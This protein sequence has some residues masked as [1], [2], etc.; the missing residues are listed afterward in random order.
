MIRRLEA[1]RVSCVKRAVGVRHS[2]TNPSLLLTHRYWGYVAECI[3]QSSALVGVV[4][5]I[6]ANKTFV[7]KGRALIRCSLSTKTLAEHVQVWWSHFLPLLANGQ[8]TLQENGGS[9]LSDMKLNPTALLLDR[10]HAGTPK[11]PHSTTIAMPSCATHSS[12]P[13]LWTFSTI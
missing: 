5:S 7:G 8:L 6:A 3:D 4:N 11:L 1:L 12:L 10:L 13:S 2:P 9:S